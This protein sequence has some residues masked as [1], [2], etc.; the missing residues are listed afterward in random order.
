MI[1]FAKRPLL[2][3]LIVAQHGFPN[4]LWGYWVIGILPTVSFYDQ[5]L[6]VGGI[7]LT[8]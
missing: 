2:R 7:A 1:G 4:P 8:L 5:F 3:T 6:L